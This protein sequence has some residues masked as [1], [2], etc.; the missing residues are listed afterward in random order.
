M[1]E[2]GQYSTYLPVA[3]QMIDTFSPSATTPVT[4]PIA[5][6]RSSNIS[7]TN[8]NSD[9]NLPPTI[10]NN[11]ITSGS[12]QL[13]NTN[14]TS[15]PTQSTAEQQ[16]GQDATEIILRPNQGVSELPTTLPKTLTVTD[17]ILGDSR[18]PLRSSVVNGNTTGLLFSELERGELYD[19]YPAVTFHFNDPTALGLVNIKHVLVGPIKSYDSPDDIL[20]E[21][22]YW[23]DLALN[24]QVVL[25]MNQPGL[26]YLIASVQFANGTSGIYSAI[27]NVDASNTKSAAEDVMDFQM[28]EGEDFNIVDKAEIGDIQSDP[29]FQRAASMIICSDLNTYGFQVCQTATDPSIVEAQQP[30]STATEDITSLFGDGEDEDEEEDDNN[31]NGNDDDDNDNDN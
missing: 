10:S 24:E 23:N 15:Q 3:Q 7:S 11:A 8:N 28:D 22:N 17:S 27:M 16:Q 14:T 6:Q 1:A 30:S 20:E 12:Q 31:G 19:W 25:E 18:L 2:P 5:Q 26:N 29:E 9:D 13:A 4:V 21:A